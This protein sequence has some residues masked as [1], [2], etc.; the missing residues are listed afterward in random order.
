MLAALVDTDALW[1][2][3]LAS[4][5]AGGGAVMAWGL[6][7]LASSRY[8]VARERGGTAA[9]GYAALAALFAVVCAGI[10]VIGFIAMTKK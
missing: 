4:F 7:V 2:I 9:V 10:V 8:A 5:A 3:V 6:V 1:K